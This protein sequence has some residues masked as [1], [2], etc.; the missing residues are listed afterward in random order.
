MVVFAEFFLVSS[1]NEAGVPGTAFSRFRWQLKR[2]DNL[3]ASNVVSSS[4]S[5][6]P[7]LQEGGKRR[8]LRSFYNANLVEALSKTLKSN[9]EN[10]VQAVDLYLVE[11]RRGR[12]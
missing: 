5:S 3:L 7:W 4:Y 1:S 11:E 6:R 10:I 9:I 8:A 2:G 12:N